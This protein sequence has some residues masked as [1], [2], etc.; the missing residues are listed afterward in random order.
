MVW[1]EDRLNENHTQQGVE[2]N[3]KKAVITIL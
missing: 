1:V 2:K 3:A